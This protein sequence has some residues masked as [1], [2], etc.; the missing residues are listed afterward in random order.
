MTSVI[1]MTTAPNDDGLQ[2]RGP[3]IAAGWDPDERKWLED[4]V[5]AVKAKHAEAVKDVV[6]YGSKARDDWK[7]D[8]DIDVL[9]ILADE[10]DGERE[11]V[12]SPAYDLSVT[13]DGLPLVP[14]KSESEWKQLGE[15]GGAFHRSVG[16]DGVS[17]LPRGQ[18]QQPTGNR[19]SKK[20]MEPITV[21]LGTHRVRRGWTSE[22]WEYRTRL[23][24]DEDGPK[25]IIE[26]R[27]PETGEWELAPEG[28]EHL[29]RLMRLAAATAQLVITREYAGQTDD[30]K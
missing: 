3:D 10:R 29:S 9:L 4:F 2:P 30:K 25:G 8:S 18:A 1:A 23:S 12:E 22:A 5:E 24:I 7:K 20:R 27:T 28:P 11:D 21:N 17:V 13:A 16:R 14:T 15:A 19:G 6:I 26:R